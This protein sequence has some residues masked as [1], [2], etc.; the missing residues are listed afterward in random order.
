MH[1]SKD[2]LERTKTGTEALQ[3]LIFNLLNSLWNLI[4]MLEV[5]SSL[6]GFCKSVFD[7]GFLFIYCSPFSDVFAQQ[8]KK[9]T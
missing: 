1:Y 7:W 2:I 9:V 5:Y 6:A 4:S 8:F 3:P